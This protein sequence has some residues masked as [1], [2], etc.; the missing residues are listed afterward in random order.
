LAGLDTAVEVVYIYDN[1]TSNQPIDAYASATD[2]GEEGWHS[3][4]VGDVSDRCYMT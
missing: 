2:F 1:H 3:D 4:G